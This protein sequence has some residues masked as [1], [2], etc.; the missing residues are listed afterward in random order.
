MLLDRLALS[1]EDSE[2]EEGSWASHVH[3]VFMCRYCGALHPGDRTRCDACGRR[4]TLVRLFAVRQKD[5]HPGYLTSCLACKARGRFESGAPREPARPVRAVTVSDIHVL[6]QNM[7]HCSDRRRLLVFADNRQEAAFQAGW[8]KD[9][10]R[11]FRLRSLMY[12]R[13]VQ[14]PISVDDLV[15]HLDRL[16]NADDEMS[17]SL[18]PRCGPH[19]G[20]HPKV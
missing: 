15:T 17:R 19:S 16:L 7:I 14:G 9:H 6:A 3:E 18:I 13:I 2:G 12:D 1:D 11:R 8:M 20:R 5:D 4:G 10:A